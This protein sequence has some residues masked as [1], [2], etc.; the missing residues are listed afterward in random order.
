MNKLRL[1]FKKKEY[2]YDETH[3]PEINW[4]EIKLVIIDNNELFKQVFSI[5]WDF[6]IF[7]SW[8]KENKNHILLEDCPI[9]NQNN[10]SLAKLV[11]SFYDTDDDLDDHLIDIMY[12]YREHH[13]I[14]FGLRGVDINDVYLGKNKNIFEISLFE[15]DESWEFEIDLVSFFKEI[16]Y[17]FHNCTTH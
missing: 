9:Q 6:R 16:E 2:P 3:D 4:G 10:T 15:E 14:R 11:H 8:L 13:N 5:E 1:F 7:L 12:D 17:Y